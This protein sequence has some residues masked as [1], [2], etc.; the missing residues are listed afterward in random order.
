MKKSACLVVIGLSLAAAG[1]GIAHA[2]QPRVVLVTQ[3]GGSLLERDDDRRALDEAISSYLGR[4]PPELMSAS[5]YSAIEKQLPA[6]LAESDREKALNRIRVNLTP[7]IMKRMITA[8]LKRNFTVDEISVLARYD[9]SQLSDEL[10]KKNSDF[11]IEVSSQ[12]R[13]LLAATIS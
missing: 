1:G 9:E 10:R 8:G 13:M 2:S 12:I 7:D 6:S 5:V 4:N 3:G 11:M